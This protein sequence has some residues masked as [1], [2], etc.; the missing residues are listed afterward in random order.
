MAPCPAHCFCLPGTGTG[1][2]LLQTA[3]AGQAGGVVPD[4]VPASLSASS[5]ELQAGQETV[6]SNA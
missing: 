2:A 4:G 1:A 5:R 3:R 6:H